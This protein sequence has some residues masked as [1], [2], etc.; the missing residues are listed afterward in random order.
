MFFVVVPSILHCTATQ[1]ALG[2]AAVHNVD[3][4]GRASIAH[5]DIASVQ[6]VKV[7]DIFKLNDFNRA[8]FIGWNEKNQE[9]CPFKVGSN[10]GKYR[11][12]EEYAYEDETEKV[13]IVYE[14]TL[15]L[16]LS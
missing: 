5:T 8:R 2:V 14:L 13:C 9:P 12:P 7:G 4:E 3:M 16:S 1:A 11:A 10:P 6:F 15:S